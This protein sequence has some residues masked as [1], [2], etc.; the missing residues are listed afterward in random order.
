MG[1]FCWVS[2]VVHMGEE[3]RKGRCLVNRRL[4]GCRALILSGSVG[5]FLVP[6]KA[7]REREDLV[8]VQVQG[9]SSVARL[10]SLSSLIGGRHARPRV[11]HGRLF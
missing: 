4:V 3:R 8:Q 11:M 7:Q 1:W 10:T 5:A 6:G 9:A 2:G